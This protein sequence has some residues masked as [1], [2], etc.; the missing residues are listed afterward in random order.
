MPNQIYPFDLNDSQ[1][2]HIKELL[3]AA[4][5]TG[6]ARELRAAPSRQRLALLRRRRRPMAHVAKGIPALA[7]RLL[8]LPAVARQRRLAASA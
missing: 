2:E 4:K 6:R 1:W 3:P 5:S 7:E 8:L